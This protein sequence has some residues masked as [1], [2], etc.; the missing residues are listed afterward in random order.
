MSGAPAPRSTTAARSR[1]AVPATL[2]LFLVTQYGYAWRVPFINDDF[3]FLDQ[4]RAMGF[5][6]LWAW[7][8]DWVGRYYRPWSR[9]LHYWVL[10]HLFGTH[11][12]PFHLVNFGLWLATMLLYFALVRRL[13]GPRAAA[14]ATAGVAAL[15]AWSL[16]VVW[17]AGAQ[18]LWM[19]LLALAAL[20]LYARRADAAATIAFALALLSKETALLLPLVAFAMLTAVAGEKP[21]RALRRL[22]PAIVL[23]AACVLLHPQLGGRLWLHAPPAAPVPGP[24]AAGALLGSLLATFNLHT[25]PRPE[26]G[27]LWPLLFG[28]AGALCLVVLV[29]A[30]WPAPGGHRAPRTR[31]DASSA[32]LAVLAATWT[33]A[34]WLPLLAPG[35]G[36]HAHYALFGMLGAWLLLGTLLAR[37]RTAALA[38]VVALVLLRALAA[39]TPSRDWGDESYLRRSA[40]F[41]HSM[42]LDLQARVPAPEPHSRL[43]FMGVPSMVGFLHGSAPALRVWYGDPTLS[44][45]LLSGY[46]ARAASEPA[47][48]DRFFRYDS[49]AGWIEVCAGR[50]DVAAGRAADPLWREDHERLAVALSRGDDWR[51]AEDEYAKLATVW[52]DSVNYAYYAGLSAVAAGDSLRGAV[53]LERALRLPGADREIRETARRLG[54]GGPRDGGRSRRRGR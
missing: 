16:P 11:V 34:G 1:W 6:R 22:A 23:A 4:T 25:L 42:R 40:E 7:H 54:V 26:F 49:T 32:E 48:P 50:E 47:G 46:R 44:G 9:E 3:A 8:G 41:L 20:L 15:A 18:E 38:V 31:A 10:Q 27:W 53:W 35:L 19:L 2:L 13:A 51:R 24:G 17:L 28:I 14:V 43:Y 52:P 5:G 12:A 37:R 33:T 36:W 29:F 21:R 45:G 39:A 30:A